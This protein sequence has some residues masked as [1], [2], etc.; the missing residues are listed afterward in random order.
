M[1]PQQ[2]DLWLRIQQRQMLALERIAESLEQLIPNSAPNYER[3]LEDFPSFTWKEIGASVD[4][5]DQYGAAVVSWKGKQFTRRSPSNKF[6][7]AIWF[8]RCIGKDDKGENL[9]E[10]LVT[11]KPLSQKE[12]DPIPQ[13]VTQQYRV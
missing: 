11:F 1:N 7:A 3:S 8:S 10:R 4:K 5:T 12:P 13:K 2:T 9:Y 6:G